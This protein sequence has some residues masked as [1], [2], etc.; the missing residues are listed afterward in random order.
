MWSA[1]ESLKETPVVAITLHNTIFSLE[2]AGKPSFWTTCKHPREYQT[3]PWNVFS[4]FF[5]SLA[6]NKGP[7][8][9]G[10]FPITW[11]H[12][13]SGWPLFFQIEGKSKYW[14][15]SVKECLCFESTHGPADILYTYLVFPGGLV[16]WLASRGVLCT[17][18]LFHLQMGQVLSE[19][20]RGKNTKSIWSSRSQKRTT[21]LCQNTLTRLNAGVFPRNVCFSVKLQ[22]IQFTEGKM[23]KKIKLSKNFPKLSTFPT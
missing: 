16:Q 14:Y 1:R 6:N 10:F 21:E 18:S 13:I 5:F 23:M 15:L 9:S 4:C 22:Q 7:L 20:G 17:D 2:W 12:Q 19:S 11:Q 3:L 8:V